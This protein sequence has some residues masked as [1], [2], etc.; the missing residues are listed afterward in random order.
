[1]TCQ[2]LQ[3]APLLPAGPPVDSAGKG[4][5]L[6]FMLVPGSAPT[7]KSDT[8]PPEISL[9]SALHALSA[10]KS[11]VDA[12]DLGEYNAGHIK[13]AICCPAS[14]V[15]RWRMH[16][17]GIDPRTP[18]VVYCAEAS[19]GKGEYVATFLLEN[20]FT[21]VSLYR[22]GWAKWTGPKE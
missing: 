15:G 9:P 16:M 4:D 20:G 6:D 22:D 3:G 5:T 7:V 11:F 18:I 2:L 12:R 10:G 13:G 21:D 17:A 14:D 1:M 19:C 8:K